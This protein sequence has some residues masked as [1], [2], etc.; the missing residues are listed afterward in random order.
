[1]MHGHG[2]NYD[3]LT[4]NGQPTQRVNPAA[5]Y[6]HR[7]Q[8]LAA[9]PS[10]QQQ[11][12]YENRAVRYANPGWQYTM[13]QADGEAAVRQLVM[14]LTVLVHALVYLGRAT[15]RGARWSVMTIQ[16]RRTGKP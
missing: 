12:V 9:L 2:Y 5:E 16:A 1:M 8:L 14:L 13:S 4:P 10:R 6:N 3:P 7:Q 11:P 15:Y